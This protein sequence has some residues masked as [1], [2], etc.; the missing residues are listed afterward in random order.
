MNDFLPISKSDMEKQEIEQLDF[1]MVT[2]DAYVDHPSFA[3]AIIS[4]YLKAHGYS[5]GMIAQPKYKEVNSFKVLGKPRL[6]FLISAGNMDSM[7]NLYSVTKHKRARDM[8]APGGKTGKRPPRT[9]IVYAQ[10]IR[11]AY[12]DV[13]IIIGGIEAS[14]RRFAHYDYWDNC[15]KP[16]ILVQ[17]DADLLVYGMGERAIVQIAEGLDGGLA[18]RDITYVEGTVYPAKDLERVYEYKAI[19]S[20]KR[21]NEDKEIYAKAFKTQMYDHK[22]VLV[23]EQENGFVVQNLPAE[24]LTQSE[25]DFVYALPYTRKAHP[26]YELPIPALEEVQYSITAVR[27]CIGACAFCALYYHQGKSVAWRSCKS[28]VSEANSFLKDKDFKGY[29]HDVGGPTANFYGVKC[30]NPN[31]RCDKRRCLTPDKC[32]YL[33]ENQSEY[34]KVLRRLREIDGVKK[35]FIRS[36]IRYDYALMDKSGDFVK[37]LAKYHVS[38]HLKLA[39]EHVRPDVLEVMGK[40]E[41]SQ[42]ERFCQKFNDVCVK[43]QKKQ[44]VLPYFMSS[45]PGATLEDAVALAEY[46]RDSGFVPEQAQDFYPTP[47]TLATCM[48]YTGINPLNNQKVYVAKTTEEKAMQRALIQYKNPKNRGIIKKAL[49][50]VDRDDL[51]GN[52]KRALVR[53]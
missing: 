28:I 13:P 52:S 24:P 11:E 53:E 1:I 20:Y 10:K 41:I 21:V 45:H 42:Y 34:L 31:G 27:G 32:K 23:Q 15:V 48:Y 38:G 2:G 5:V 25:L 3:H 17:S 51:I 36:G 18:P 50:M 12:G 40:P 14:L 46:I 47:G 9:T 26:S 22:N 6:G 37:E 19:P 49:R 4:R 7:V 29:I 44:Y 16:S 33:K 43:E 8:Y 35:V 30:T 39:P